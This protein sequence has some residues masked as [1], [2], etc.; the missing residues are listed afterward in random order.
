MLP[1]VALIAAGGSCQARGRDATG[2]SEEADD[3]SGRATRG[4]Q[5]WRGRGDRSGIKD[6][7][8]HLRVRQVK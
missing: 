1:H 6:A 3:C 4:K 5:P 7:V 8:R 2:G